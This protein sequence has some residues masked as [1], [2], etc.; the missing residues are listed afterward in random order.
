MFQ[1][2]INISSNT[3]LKVNE[4]VCDAIDLVTDVGVQRA[5]SMLGSP[6]NSKAWMPYIAIG[7]GTTPP[8][9]IDLTL[10][11]ELHRKQGTVTVINNTYFVEAEFGIDEPE[12]G[13]TFR[14][15]GIFDAAN[16]GNMG[17]RWLLV[18]DQVKEEDDYIVIRCAISLT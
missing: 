4:V 10:E 1:D 6:Y 15:V 17:A 2:K 7:Y 8:S 14:E 9:N 3:E 18:E 12:G 5:A 16:G 11:Y 13:C